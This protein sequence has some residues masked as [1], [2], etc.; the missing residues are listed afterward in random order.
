MIGSEA[1][2][3]MV[4]PHDGLT[5]VGL[6]WMTS[7]AS[8]LLCGCASMPAQRSVNEA[9]LSSVPAA[10]VPDHELSVLTNSASPLRHF[11]AWQKLNPIWWFGNADDPVPPADYRPGKSWRKL[12]WQLR[13]PGHNLTFYV[14][15]VADKRFTRKGPYPG[16]ISNPS[17]GWN[18]AV[19]RYHGL[20]LPFVDYRHGGFEFYWGWRERGNLG[21]K[22][23]FAA[24]RDHSPPKLASARAN[25]APDAGL[26]S[27]Q[28]DLTSQTP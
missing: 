10:S 20:R 11:S 9:A 18:W 4:E 8:L 5:F 23:N 3:K 1:Q 7:L 28:G 24:P 19:C 21:L 27:F 22:L 2:S 25:R 12:T 6:L 14:L 26:A 17:G 15:G 13:N 16:Q